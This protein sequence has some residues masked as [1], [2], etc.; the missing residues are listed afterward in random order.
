MSTAAGNTPP[1]P[2]T[3]RAALVHA[4]DYVLKTVNERREHVPPVSSRGLVSFPFNLTVPE[5]A[6]NANAS[7]GVR[8]VLKRLLETAPRLV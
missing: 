2:A 5:A 8:S 1:A 7:F 3:V 4:I 6:Q